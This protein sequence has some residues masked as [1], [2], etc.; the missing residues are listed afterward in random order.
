MKDYNY[1]K[2]KDLEKFFDI[3]PEE[4]AIQHPMEKS[5]DSLLFEQSYKTIDRLKKLHNI[6]SRQISYIDDQ[7]QKCIDS[8]K[9]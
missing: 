4:L 2:D 5:L 6:N 9:D 7:L 8:L 1:D 3:N